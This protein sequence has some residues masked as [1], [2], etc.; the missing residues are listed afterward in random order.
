MFAACKRALCFCVTADCDSGDMVKGL[1]G[2]LGLGVDMRGVSI[3]LLI[4]L[5]TGFEL[6]MVVL[7]KYLGERMKENDGRC[8]LFPKYFYRTKRMISTENSL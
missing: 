8:S 5:L 7:K 6:G 1:Q 4:L 2:V 3:V